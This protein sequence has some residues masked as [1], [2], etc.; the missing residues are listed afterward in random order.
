MKLI[1]YCHNLVKPLDS[2]YISLYAF[3]F[4]KVKFWIGMK[5]TRKF[6]SDFF[7]IFSYDRLI[8]SVFHTKLSNKQLFEWT[9]ERIIK[10]DW[11]NFNIEMKLRIDKPSRGNRWIVNLKLI[12]QTFVYWPIVLLLHCIDSVLSRSMIFDERP[13]RPVTEILRLLSIAVKFSSLKSAMREPNAWAFP[14]IM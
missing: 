1:W 14:P 9:T 5:I 2:S 4:R 12:N 10:F 7:E 6:S 13:R 3:N 11:T 8:Y